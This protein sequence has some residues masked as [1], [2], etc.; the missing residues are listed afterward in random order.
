[1]EGG[2][3]L[4]WTATLAPRGLLGPLAPLLVHIYRLLMADCIEPPHAHVS[5]GGG[6]CKIWLRP[7]SIARTAGYSR[8]EENAILE[9]AQR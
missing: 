8:R 5:G 4:D 9:F 1:M 2:T 6:A 7:V 3:R